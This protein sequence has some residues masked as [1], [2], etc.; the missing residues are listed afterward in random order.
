MIKF[1]VIPTDNIHITSNYGWRIHPITKKKQF[2]KGIDLVCTKQETPLIYT[3]KAGTVKTQGWNKYRGNYVVIQHNGFA[4]L[5]Q[6]LDYY[7]T[8]KGQYLCDGG[9]IGC[10]GSTGAS[11]GQHLHFE[12]YI[13][14][15]H[16]KVTTD[17]KKYLEEI[18]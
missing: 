1:N 2:H 5:Y 13:G 6:H 9:Y 18:K 15:Y 3:V 8:K 11:T 7:V 14:Q 12:L 16:E 10:M 17:P 4:T